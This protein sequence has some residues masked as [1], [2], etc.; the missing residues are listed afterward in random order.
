MN[1][2]NFI[3]LSEIHSKNLSVLHSF[4]HWIQTMPFSSLKHVEI[5]TRTKKNKNL[6]LRWECARCINRTRINLVVVCFNGSLCSDVVV[7]VV[8]ND[9]VVERRKSSNNCSSFS[10]NTALLTSEK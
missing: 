6:F 7:D 2:Y 4:L 1:F 8:D 5:E 3:K 9:A 10:S